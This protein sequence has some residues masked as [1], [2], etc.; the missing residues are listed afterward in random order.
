M[1]QCLF[2]Y[3]FSFLTCLQQSPQDGIAV[4]TKERRPE[5]GRRTHNWRPAAAAASCYNSGWNRTDP[6]RWQRPMLRP[7]P[8]RSGPHH[9]SRGS[10]QVLPTASLQGLQGVQRAKSDGLIH[11]RRDRL[12]LHRLLQNSV[13]NSNHLN[14]SAQLHKLVSYKSI[15]VEGIKR[16]GAQ[17]FDRLC[18]DQ[19]AGNFLN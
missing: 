4:S 16:W 10:L 1:I 17:E 5:D 11:F 9:Q 19:R 3:F 18:R 13:S 8:D 2:S 12:G 7:V 6:W 15:D 14:Q